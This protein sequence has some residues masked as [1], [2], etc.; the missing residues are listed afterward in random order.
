MELSLLCNSHVLLCIVE[1]GKTVIFSSDE[2]PSNIVNES[3]IP[4]VMNKLVDS[5]NKANSSLLQ[6][7]DPK[8]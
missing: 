1:N 4:A 7:R 8:L 2:A 6:I 5:L 3:L